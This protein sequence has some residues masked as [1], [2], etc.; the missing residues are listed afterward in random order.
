M[1]GHIDHCKDFHFYSRGAGELLESSEQRS[2]M[3]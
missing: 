3:I 2:A 1:S